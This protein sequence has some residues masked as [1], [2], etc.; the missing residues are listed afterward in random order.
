LDKIERDNAVAV[1]IIPVWPHKPWW[2][3]LRSGAWGARVAKS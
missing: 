2:Q 3:R 1:L